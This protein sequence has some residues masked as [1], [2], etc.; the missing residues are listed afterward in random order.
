MSDPVFDPDGIVRFAYD[1]G[2]FSFMNSRWGW[3]LMETVHFVG[4]SMLVGAVGAFDLRMM[5][6]V[7]GISMSALHRLVWVGVIGFCLNAAS[8]V[9]FFVSAAGQYLYNPAFQ[10]KFAAMI[11]AG[12]N[13]A[14]FYVTMAGRVL[15]A[16]EPA[17][18]PV[19]ARIMAAVSLTSWLAVVAF[20]RL[21][22]F[23][24]PPYHWCFWCTGG[25]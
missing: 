9:M 4:L 1:A 6:V 8:G 25:G 14:L 16:P 7:R 5:G 22:T 17:P 2:I 10:L 11:I 23:F 21:L 12:L 18:I 13:V 3:P 19:A 15:N 20:G 24:R